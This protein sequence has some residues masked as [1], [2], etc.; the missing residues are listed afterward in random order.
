MKK[1]KQLAQTSDQVWKAP[2]TVAEE[3]DLLMARRIAAAA[4]REIPAESLEAY[5]RQH[6]DPAFEEG[7]ANIP[8]ALLDEFNRLHEEFNRL[9][10]GEGHLRLPDGSRWILVSALMETSTDVAVPL[11]NSFLR[12]L[13][14]LLWE[15]KVLL[16][17]NAVRTLP[18]IMLDADTLNVRRVFC[19]DP[20]CR[21]WV[22]L[23]AD[24]E[25]VDRT[26]SPWED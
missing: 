10:E 8:K 13:E 25:E 5:W 4:T 21:R 11:D 14:A 12:R 24:A 19:T 15:H 2:V 17:E 7:V 16:P 1:R 18:A 22:D 3:L 6:D 20:T 23:V 26:H 9:Y